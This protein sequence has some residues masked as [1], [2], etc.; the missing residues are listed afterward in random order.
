MKPNRDYLLNLAEKAIRIDLSDKDFLELSLEQFRLHGKWN[1]IYSEWIQYLKIDISS[2]SGLEQIPFLP[3]RFFKQFKVGLEF[4]NRI[5]SLCFTSSTTTGTQPSRHYVPFPEVYVSSFLKAFEQVYGSISEW[6]IFALLPGYLERSGSSLVYMADY[7]IQHSNSLLSGFYL[8]DFSSLA[9]NLQ[10][11]LASGR[12]TMLLGVSF[13]LL[14][15]IESPEFALFDSNK[16]SNLVVMETGGMKGRRKELT[17]MELHLEL[18]KAFGVDYIHSE[19]G[20]TELLSQAYSL[21]EG[22]FNTPPWMKIQLRETDNPLAAMSLINRVGGVNVIDLANCFS[23]PFLAID[24]LGKVHEN[25][26]FEILGRFD[27][28]EVRGCNLMLN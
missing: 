12:K 16:G 26:Q 27:Q 1:P 25:G 8:N 20:M 15:F 17:R 3:V 6:T 14:D 5:D 21:G 23:C 24:D 18:T 2:V 28:A 9:Q 22:V 19:Y 11:S 7:L 4:T 10:N 13:G